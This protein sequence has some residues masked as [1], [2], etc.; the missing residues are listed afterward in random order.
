MLIKKGE[1]AM[2]DTMAIKDCLDK[3]LAQSDTVFIV[4]HNRPDMDALGSSIALASI[5][6][7]NNKKYYI[8]INDEIEKIES[9]TRGVLKKIKG[10]YPIITLSEAESLITDNSL[11]VA[12]D[13]NKTYMVSTRKIFD[14]FKNIMVIDHHQVDENTIKT[15]YLFTNPTLSS[16]CEEMSRLVFAY[17]APIN[18]DEANYL[19]AGIYLDTN[20]TTINTSEETYRVCADLVHIGANST[21]ANKLFLKNYKKDRE[22]QRIISH[23]TLVEPFYAIC[24]QDENNRLLYC[25]EDIGKAADY[26]LDFDVLITFAIGKV[27]EETVSVSARSK[28]TIDVSR[29]M[30]LLSS[31]SGGSAHLA[32][33][34]IK[35]KTVS[36]VRDELTAIVNSPNQILDDNQ[37][38]LSL[39]RIENE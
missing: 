14:R 15:D 21:E 28:E 35:G 4:P 34:K 33:A 6:K 1:E 2:Q 27:D 18:K 13:V 31:E 38:Q 32:A 20:K 36:E 19:L 11:M 22:I 23:A 7:K 39:K 16:T 17:D 30:K 29:I 26:F 12:V 10:M 3:L 9:A 8:I 37:M 24:S 5:C 25:P